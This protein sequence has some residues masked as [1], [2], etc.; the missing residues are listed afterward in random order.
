M[1]QKKQRSKE[2]L[3]AVLRFRIRQTVIYGPS[4]SGSFYHQAKKLRK[5][6]IPTALW[7]LFDFLSLKNDVKVPSKSDKQ[8]WFLLAS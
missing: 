6:L 8:I 4:G 1:S 5:T 2:K 7:L 3:E